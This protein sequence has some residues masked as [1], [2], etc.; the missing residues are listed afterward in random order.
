M[1]S[2]K[3]L[4][5]K[6]SLLAHFK[7]GCQVL[8]RTHVSPPVPNVRLL[9]HARIDE[10]LY[11]RKVYICNS[12]TE[13]VPDRLDSRLGVI[14]FGQMSGALVRGFL[15]SGILDAKD[16]CASVKSPEKRS[17]LVE[18]G[19]EKIF[20][21]ALHGGAEE[22]AKNSDVVFVGVKPQVIKPV[23]Q[24]LAPHIEPRHLIVSIAAG[25]KLSYLEDSL[26]HGARVIRV[27]PNTP[28]LVQAGASAYALGAYAGE[29]DAEIVNALL[30]KVGVAMKVQ[31]KMIDGVTGVSGSGPAYVFMMIEAMADGGVKAGL[32]REMALTLAAQTA[33]GAA[34][35]VLNTN[36][37]G[38]VH[39]GVLKDQV[40]SPAGA[41]IDAIAELESAGV[42]SA[43]IQAV[44]ASANRSKELG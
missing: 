25:I 3:I 36:G 43:F 21:D 44:M 10:R 32:P 38:L 2:C 26:G 33:K 1:I 13:D 23:L 22:V 8:N 9:S 30:S 35:M 7:H 16:V 29:K 4:R 28:S 41:T 14:G 20:G 17:Q 15:S 12:G 40:A 19:V 5:P 11:H 42:R 18:M 31:E 6:V 37:D 39:P 34:E 24:A 27:M